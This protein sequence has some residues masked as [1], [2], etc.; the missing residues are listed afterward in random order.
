MTIIAQKIHLF[1][2][3]FFPAPLQRESVRPI[4]FNQI[5]IFF[6]LIFKCNNLYVK[7]N[8]RE[9]RIKRPFLRLNT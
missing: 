5:K 7:D 4:F 6:P 9:T 2:F 1:I 3:G 8:L